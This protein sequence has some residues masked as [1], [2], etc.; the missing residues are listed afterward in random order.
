MCH[1]PPDDVDPEDRL[2]AIPDRRIGTEAGR[3]VTAQVRNDHAVSRRSEQ[4]SDIGIA[5]NVVGPPVQQDDRRAIVRTGVGVPDA[6]H[7]RIDLFKRAER[8]IGSR[9][10]RRLPA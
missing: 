8:T 9:R 1:S 5:V 3:T 4:D 6:Q 10:H 7:P 2:L